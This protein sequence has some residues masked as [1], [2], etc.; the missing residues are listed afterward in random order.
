MV[1]NVARKM[2]LCLVVAAGV[3]LATGCD[4]DD[5]YFAPSGLC[6]SG[7]RLGNF[8]QGLPLQMD[9]HA[10]PYDPRC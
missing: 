2:V 7:F 6:G 5:S 9:C 10:N 1:K 8:N 4:E 3:V